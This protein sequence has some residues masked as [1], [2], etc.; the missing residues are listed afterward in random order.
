MY[1]SVVAAVA[2]ALAAGGAAAHHSFAVFFDQKKIVRISGT[3]TH[4]RFVNPHGEIALDVKGRNGG[5][6]KWR[7]ETNAPVILRRRGWSA[8]SL[9]HGDMVTIEGWAS[10][11]GK[12]YI[13]LYKASRPDG[14]VIGIPFEQSA[15]Q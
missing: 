2:I 4:F 5:V 13:R 3:V 1:R 11:D 7:V 14:T 9:K 12:R 8:S 6:E 10:R 15:Q